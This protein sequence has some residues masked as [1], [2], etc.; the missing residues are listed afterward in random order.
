M[1]HGMHAPLL[2]SERTN[3]DS[4]VR[5]ESYPS[6]RGHLICLGHESLY[7]VSLCCQRRP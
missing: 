6:T 3:Q 7:T 4:D 1:E 2:D 5:K